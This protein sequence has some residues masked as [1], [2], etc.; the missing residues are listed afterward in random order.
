[1]DGKKGLRFCVLLCISGLLTLG[2][3]FQSQAWGARLKDIASLKGVRKNQL[4]GYG[5]VVGLNGTGDGTGTQ[6]TVQSLVNMMERLGIHATADQ[7]KVNNVA[8]VMVT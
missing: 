6:F 7:V 1:M 8:A 5:L 4:I 3:F 2:I